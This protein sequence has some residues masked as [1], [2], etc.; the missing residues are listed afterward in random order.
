M[1]APPP[2][3]VGV[4]PGQDL[5]DVVQTKVEVR[6]FPYPIY[7]REEFLGRNRAVE[8]LARR[9]A[10][11]ASAAG[12]LFQSLAEIAEQITPSAGA[13]LGVMNHLLQLSAGDFL[14]LL[15][16][17]LKNKLALLDHVARAE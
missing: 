3:L 14:F 7:A 4:G 11:I 10:I 16:G 9:K 5:D 6:S 1:M 8:S 17:L 15:V 12:F 13:A 2:D